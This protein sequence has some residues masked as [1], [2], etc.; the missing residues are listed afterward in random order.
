MAGSTTTTYA[1]RFEGLSTL[2][3]DIRLLSD[4]LTAELRAWE[5]EGA[6]I[7]AVAIEAQAPRGTADEYDK[8]P[9]LLARTVRPGVSARGGTVKAGGGKAKYGGVIHFGWQARNIAPNYFMYRGLADARPEI[10]HVFEAGVNEVVAR[11][12]EFEGAG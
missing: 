2:K 10:I 8:H 5:L 1:V 3:R 6:R 7:A 4:E 11:A 9:G 12:I